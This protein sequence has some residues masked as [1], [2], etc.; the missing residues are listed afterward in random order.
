[1]GNVRNVDIHVRLKGVEDVKKGMKDIGMSVAASK[2]I[3]EAIAKAI[4][5]AAKGAVNFVKDSTDQA[6]E[7]EN[8]LAGVAK[9]TNFTGVGLENFAN[10]IMDLSH[11]IPVT[12]SELAHL[13]EIAA[14]LGI[15]QNNLIEFVEVVAAM[16]VTTNMSA[17]DAATSMARLANIFNTSASDY[18]KMGSSIVE[19]GNNFA[20]TES[21]ITEMALRMAGMGS[22]VGMTEADVIAYSAALSSIGMEANAGGTA[23]QKL[24]QRFELAAETDKGLREL[25]EITG[26]TTGEFKRLW[27]SS[28]T[29]VINQ[30][31]AGLRSI[32]HEGGSA[33]ATLEE[34]EIKETRLTR[35][36]LGLSNA[37][38]LV[39]E[40]VD[41]SNAA[42]N[43]NLAL[44]T[45]AGKRYETTASRIQ[46][47]QNK[48]DNSRVAFG[49]T[50]KDIIASNK[51]FKAD[52]ATSLT[53]ELREFNLD[54]TITDT[55]ATFEAQKN[56]IDENAEAARKL[57]LGLE[58][59]G[60]VDSLDPS[61]VK[62][63]R[64]SLEALSTIV[65]EVNNMWDRQ[66]LKIEGGTAAL[67]EAITS[68]QN[69]AIAEAKIVKTTENAE[70]YSIAEEMVAAKR[71]EL[72]IALAELEVIQKEYDDYL[73]SKP[74][75]GVGVYADYGFDLELEEESKRLR[76][77]SQYVNE[78]R[79]DIEEAEAYLAEYSY[80]VD[81]FETAVS[82]AVVASDA[83]AN[84]TSGVN[85][86]QASAIAG[87]THLDEELKTIISDYHEVRDSI[88]EA[89]DSAISGFEK[90]ELP[91]IEAPESNIEGLDS[92]LEF[93]E[94]YREL[95]AKAKE[96]GIASE[97]IAQYADG[98]TGSYSALASLVSGTE[99]DA[100]IINEKF[101]EVSAAKDAL[102]T[103][104][105]AVITGV[106]SSVGEITELA[107]SLVSGADVS[108]AMYSTGVNDVQNLING[109]NSKI[110]A[111]KLSV[112]QVRAISSSMPSG[113]AVE[114]T[115][116]AGLSYV[117]HDG[118]I[119]QLHRGE[120]VLTALEAKAYRAEQF[121]NYPDAVPTSNH[122]SRNYNE[123]INSTTRIGTAVFYEN[124]DVNELAN[125]IADRNKRKARARGAY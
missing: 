52:I 115:H 83:Y 15:D 46:I 88:R 120:M 63:Y 60:D 33:V 10:K 105:A 104:L 119:A 73:A 90:I 112:A 78:L 35:A 122:V 12:A 32:E 55:T 17:E 26:L 2:T 38:T 47:A 110:S 116:A 75:A 37:G 59:L 80:V 16:G 31:L 82:D 39:T 86:A 66:T 27:D 72:A 19:L 53:K 118:Y 101:A 58:S 50:W 123:T 49:D 89:L 36:I 4:I 51:E 20:T 42:W 28:P 43:D 34:L 69:F 56:S 48:I 9:T 76:E 84:A 74:V 25:A 21:E 77:H 54:R 111:L 92:Q 91:E 109:I 5:K 85:D 103:D 68:A 114:G 98:S 99:E 108:D 107:N 18:S 29:D 24:F 96:M 121:T 62:N 3:W 22:I 14:Q 93:I 113:G 7:F 40:A 95:I 70:A 71:A 106:E 65:P 41:M 44:A 6:I 11:E 117:P 97:I 79:G 81:E 13:A 125:R 94:S 100:A 102:A 30:F 64:A 124:A 1:M 8:A 57:V 87:L 67:N 61:G 23:M 45:E